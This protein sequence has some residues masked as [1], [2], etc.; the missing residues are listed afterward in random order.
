MNKQRHFIPTFIAAVILTLMAAPICLAQQLTLTPYKASGIYDIG[1][2]VGWTVALPANA[3]PAG[4]YAYTVK[5]N[6]QDVIKRGKLDF[7]T[8]RASI[9]V[10]LDEPA[11]VYAEISPAGGAGTILAV[12]A[13]V[14]PEKLQ[15]SV[16]RP[17][18]FDRFWEAKIKILKKVPERAVLT[19][20]DSGRLDIEYAT[21]RMDHVNG[22][23]VY[24]QMAR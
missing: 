11:M 8:G 21:I 24:G 4:E 23:H 20:S 9:E 7:S 18:D 5:K 22:T 19:P 15:P 17:A 6:N 13:A 12:G 2:R 10:T 1:E 3:V 14:A 16:P